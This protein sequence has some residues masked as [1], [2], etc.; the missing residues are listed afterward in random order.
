[1][2]FPSFCWK[3]LFFV[4]IFIQ[5]CDNILIKGGVQKKAPSLS[6]RKKYDPETH[7]FSA[8]RA[9]HGFDGLYR[10]QQLQRSRQ[11]LPRQRPLPPH[12]KPPHP[13]PATTAMNSF[14]PTPAAHL[15]PI[16]PTNWKKNSKASMTALNLNSTSLSR[17]FSWT[18]RT[19]R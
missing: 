14:W 2:S 4:D 3:A 16:R 10:V 13:T 8:S 6:R 7:S 5:M 11:N 15:S 9:R 19:S 18:L 17:P 12:R 1:M